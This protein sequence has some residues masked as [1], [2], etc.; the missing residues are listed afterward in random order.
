MAVGFLEFSQIQTLGQLSSN[1]QVLFCIIVPLRTM[2]QIW[3]VWSWPVENCLARQLHPAP[4]HQIWAPQ[5]G[6]WYRAGIQ[7]HILI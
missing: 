6:A 2:I 4:V 7:K 5:I 1:V 3:T